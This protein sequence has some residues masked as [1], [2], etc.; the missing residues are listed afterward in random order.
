MGPEHLVYITSRRN[1]DSQ[2]STADTG[3]A[4]QKTMTV[5]SHW[6]NSIAAPNSHIRCQVDSAK[7]LTVASQWS[8]RIASS[9]WFCSHSIWL[10][11]L[12]ARHISS[13]WLDQLPTFSRFVDMPGDHKL[14]KVEMLLTEIQL[15][16]INVLDEQYGQTRSSTCP[17]SPSCIRRLVV[18]T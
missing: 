16:V 2:P 13:P 11:V 8:C 3:G 14:Q 12:I 18:F 6:Y 15:F 7:L 4:N 9:L 1:W 17:R 10:W 5:K